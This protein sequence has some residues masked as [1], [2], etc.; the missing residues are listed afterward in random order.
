LS[1]RLEE[2]AIERPDV[3]SNRSRT[4]AKEK[5]ESDKAGEENKGRI[6]PFQHPVR[7]APLAYT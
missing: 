1:Y 6:L 3:S 4:R 7:R 2:V 5:T